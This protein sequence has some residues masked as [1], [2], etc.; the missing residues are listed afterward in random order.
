MDQGHQ[1]TL[2]MI[3]LPDRRGRMRLHPAGKLVLHRIGHLS[4]L[5]KSTNMRSLERRSDEFGSAILLAALS[6]S[7]LAG[8]ELT[9]ENA[10]IATTSSSS[11]HGQTSL[12]SLHSPIKTV[13]GSTP[14]GTHPPPPGP[15]T[16]DYHGPPYAAPHWV[17][18]TRGLTWW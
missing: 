9:I 2:T 3:E 17:S 14:R 6:I 11:S 12:L 8:A 18:C 4:T 13:L 15:Y 7:L 10:R 16:R 1:R 5:G